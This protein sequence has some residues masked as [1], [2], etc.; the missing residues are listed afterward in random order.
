MES[1]DWDER[2]RTAELVWRA[3]PNRWVAEE[4]AGLPPG[5]AID[6]ACGEGRNAV[7]LAEQGWDATG[8]DF[9]AVGLDKGR[10]MAA[11]RGVQVTWVEADVRTWEAPSPA[12]LV[13]V[14]YLQLPAG[15]RRA[16]LGHAAAALAPGGTLLVVGHDRSNLEHGV[17]GPQDPAVL[18]TPEDVVDDLQAS[19]VTVVVQRAEVVRRP[20]DTASGRADALDC[21]VRAQRPA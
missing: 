16:A 14:C 2:Y 21:L 5:R 1:E 6:L 20:V 3:E 11:E 8:V 7:W 9:S 12:D 10:R 17:G 19:G 4:V 13:I 18:Y 15:A